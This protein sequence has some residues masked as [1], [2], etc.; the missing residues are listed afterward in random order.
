M[1][2]LS[3]VRDPADFLAE[4]GEYLAVDPLLTNVL[5]TVATRAAEQA[6]EGVT[7]PERDWWLV[8]RDGSAVVGAAMRTAPAAP[9]P[10]YVAPM[11]SEAAVLLGRALV[12]RGE[13]VLAVNG[14]LPAARECAEEVARLTGSNAEVAVHMRQH[15]A[16]AV[17]HEPA[18]AGELRQARSSEAALVQQWFEEFFVDADAQAG[19]PDGAHAGEVPPLEVTRFRVEEGSVWV[20]V[21]DGE[22]VHMTCTNPPS[23]GVVRLGPVY[24]PLAYRGRGYAGATVAALTRRALADGH[25]PTLFTDQANPVSNKLYASIG[26]VPVVD[27]VNLVLR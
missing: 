8:V 10:L 7:Q 5:A 4:A 16:D 11:P 21:V 6:R 13:E 14:A 18:A 9:F 23:Y 26:Y 17:T 24:T 1:V 12:E 2:Q 27:A 20:R 19:R 22:P 3:F 15:R 25:L